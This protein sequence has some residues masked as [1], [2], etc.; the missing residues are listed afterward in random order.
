MAL[1]EYMI[2]PTRQMP[3]SA[4]D[5]DIMDEALQFMAIS[6][7]L[8]KLVYRLAFKAIEYSPLF[9]LGK[10][11][12][13]TGLSKTDQHTL[14]EKWIQAKSY[15]PRML[16]KA[17]HL[18]V[19][20][21]YY[22]HPAPANK[23][24]YTPAP[25]QINHEVNYQVEDGN[26]FHQD[27]TE[28]AD[29]CIIGSGAGGAVLAKELSEQGLDVVVLEEGA[30]FRTAD[31]NGHTLDMFKAMY[32]DNGLTF[33]LGLPSIVLPLGK[34]VGG[35]TV[36]NSGTCLR[37]PDKLLERW[38]HDAALRHLA[39]DTLTPYYERVENILHVHEP[40]LHL[41]SPGNLRFKAGADSLGFHGGILKRNIHGCEGSGI[42]CL[43]C[44]TGGKQSMQLSYI[45]LAIR[46]G[47]RLYANCQAEKLLVDGHHVQ[48]VQA[49]L[50]K[51][52]GQPQPILTVKAKVTILACGTIHSPGMLAKSG[53]G[54]LSPQIGTHLTIHPATKVSA[55]FDDPV[56]AYRGIPQGYYVDEFLTDGIMM[57]G[58][59]TPPALSAISVPVYG[60][61]HKSF[62]EQYDRLASFGLLISDTSHG[63]LYNQKGERPWVVYNLNQ[64]DKQRL[65]KGLGLL[66]DIFFEAGAREVYLPIAKFPHLKSRDDIPKLQNALLKTTD[67]ELSSF[68]PL[69]TCRMGIDPRTAVIDHHC[70]VFEMDNLYICDGSIFPSSLGV[71]PQ[72]TIMAMATRT[73]AH[74]KESFFS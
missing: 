60:Q 29:V 13:F 34:C 52:P 22:G 25:P 68:H 17:M 73:A 16:L 41:L 10:I 20:T 35:T 54:Q 72:L 53:L 27:M 59:D 50:G 11:N 57:E 66:A 12:T 6:P 58:I 1:S 7:P 49:R 26:T 21:T 67:I 47:T 40:P 28:F 61:E 24:H 39:M 55:L 51:T 48:G 9:V 14:I 3:D 70:K 74:I 42:C 65:Q 23:L 32:R 44:P 36:I 4:Q 46:N 43:G 56:H 30:F 15:V 69:G 33:T 64:Q 38:A 62:M 31:F 63:R 37:L 71:N 8:M 18:P 5:L 45:P 19:L 2:P